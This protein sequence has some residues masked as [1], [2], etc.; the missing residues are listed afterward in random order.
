[1]PFFL[2][3]FPLLVFL[4]YFWQRSSRWIRLL[5]ASTIVFLIQWIFVGNGIA[6]YGL[7]MFLGFAVGLELLIARA[8][9][10]LNKWLMVTLTFFSIAICLVNRFWQFDTQKNLFEYPLGKVSALALREMTI[11]DYDDITRS[12]L[13]RHA[14]MPDQPY[15]YRM[16]TFISYFIPKNR[17]ILPLA[18]HQLGMFNC[19]N[20]ERDHALTLKRL[21]ALGFNSIIFDTNTATI[22]KDPNGTL[23]QKVD[24]FIN[25]AN[26]TSLGLQMAVNDPGNGIAYILL[27]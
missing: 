19:I 2:L 5:F 9:D 4:P 25:F 11:P 7:G 22:E 1:L 14:S 8:P 20:Q 23:H 21:K 27:P 26:D 6:W 12:V 24:A 16:G 15:T 18:D 17:E 13:E 3:L 10:Q